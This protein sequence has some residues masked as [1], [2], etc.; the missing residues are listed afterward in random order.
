M[1]KRHSNEKWRQEL[2]QWRMDSAVGA[3]YL[4][5]SD[6]ALQGI[7]WTRQSAPM[8]AALKGRAPGTLLLARA[9]RELGEYL[10]GKRRKFT[11]PLEARGTPFQMSVWAELSKIPYG[12]TCS[13]AEIA[14]RLK[15]PR[16]GRAVGTANG[17]N[18]LSIMVPC[19]RVITSSGKLGGYAG[20]LAIKT[21]LLELEEIQ[22]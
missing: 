17:K 14:V 1:N 20:G 12:K 15:N 2:A 3:I 9:V 7:H 10:E 22:L 18:P 13:Y 19:H 4:V 6:R 8:A 5:A 11:L 21:R 16:A